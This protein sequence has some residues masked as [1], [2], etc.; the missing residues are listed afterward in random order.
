MSRITAQFLADTFK[1]KLTGKVMKSVKIDDLVDTL[2]DEVPAAAFEATA[3]FDRGIVVLCKDV[4]DDSASEVVAN[5]LAAHMSLK[6]D[7]P[8]TLYLSSGGGQSSSGLSII[9][10]IHSLRRSGRV[11]NTH[12]QGYAMSMASFI[13]QAGAKR[14]IEPYG[15]MMLHNIHYSVSYCERQDFHEDALNGTHKE[16]DAALSIYATRTGKPVSYWVN[17]LERRDWYLSAEEA[18][19]ENLVDEILTTP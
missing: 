12:I 14:F 1:R 8:I 15:I 10:T 4:D 3:P 19:A 9:S 6:A 16:R 7:K 11:I 2:M 18:L 5:L 17:A 13:A